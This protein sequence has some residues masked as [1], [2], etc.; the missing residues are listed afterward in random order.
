MERDGRLLR[1]VRIRRIH[2][3]A[4]QSIETKHAEMTLLFDRNTIIDEL[5]K[6]GRNRLDRE[7]GC[8]ASRAT[9]PF[10]SPFN[11]SVWFDY[12]RKY[13]LNHLKLY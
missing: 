4:I 11:E 1:A 13:W 12:E 9:T 7:D 6:C 8:V 2:N 5:K 3:T 10:V